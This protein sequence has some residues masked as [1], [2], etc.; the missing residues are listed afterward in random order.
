MR[1]LGAFVIAA[2]VCA[3][4]LAANSSSAQSITNLVTFNGPNGANPA[5]GPLVQATN[6]LLFGTT[7]YGGDLYGGT[8]GCPNPYGCGS[9]FDM[10]TSGA[11]TTLD[12][13]APD[14]GPG[15][16]MNALIQANDG[17]FYGTS[18]DGGANDCGTVF[19]VTGH[20][21]L[22]TLY[23]FA[24]DTNGGYPQGGLVQATNGFLYGTTSSAGAYG[25]GTVFEITTAGALTTLYNFC[26]AG[27][28]NGCPDGSNP[29]AGMIQGSDGNLYGT[30]LHGAWQSGTVFKMTLAGN[31]TTLYSF[32]SEGHCLDGNTPQSALTEGPDGAFYGTAVGGGE[33]GAGC[34]YKITRSGQYSVVFSFA[35]KNGGQPI[36]ALVFASDGNFYGTTSGGWGA[37]G[38]LFKLTP[39]GTMT[40]L[41]GF[42][43]EQSCADGEIPYAGLTQHTNGTLYGTTN[44]GGDLD[45]STGS[46]GCGTIYSVSA[47][48]PPF[49]AARP[50]L[51]H[52]GSSVIILGTG[53]SGATSVTFNGTPAQFT[54]VSSTEIKAI[55]PT[56]ATSGKIQASLPTSTLSTLLKFSVN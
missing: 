53:L 23:R 7:T 18:L 34:A 56:G 39:S 42:C 20:G 45:C 19:K 24:C 26:P 49:I 1:K 4:C 3:V 17:N 33:A 28:G 9:V 25:S 8:S 50:M 27:E 11:L 37:T 52:V 35:G 6:G 31:V 40:V 29:V 32:C 51:G 15:L 30:T 21:A 12:S 5:Y 41:H 16:P 22:T 36:G 46:V 10:N 13:F 47:A 44:Q 48:L 43:S 14:G 55:V 38:T 2:S 54:V